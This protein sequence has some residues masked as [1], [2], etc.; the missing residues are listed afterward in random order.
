[1]L[2]NRISI[3]TNDCR[4]NRHCVID[5]PASIPVHSPY[6]SIMCAQYTD[7]SPVGLQSY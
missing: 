5:K 4:S 7:D 1:M 3:V 2:V 6:Y